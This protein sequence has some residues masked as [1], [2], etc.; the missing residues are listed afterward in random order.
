MSGEFFLGRAAVM[1]PGTVMLIQIERNLLQN[2]TVLDARLSTR[3]PESLLPPNPRRVLPRHTVSV[4]EGVDLKTVL[5][6]RI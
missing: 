4:L 5:Q 1:M 6:Y 2:Q 3:V